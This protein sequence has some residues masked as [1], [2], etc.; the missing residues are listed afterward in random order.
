MRVATI[1]GRRKVP[2]V[3]YVQKDEKK[4]IDKK[5]NEEEK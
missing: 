4:K 2:V 5:E 1:V 3:C